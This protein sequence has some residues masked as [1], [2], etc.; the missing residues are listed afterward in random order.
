MQ[1]VFCKLGSRHSLA[2]YKSTKGQTPIANNPNPF[3]P[4]SVLACALVDERSG[5]IGG[6]VKKLFLRVIVGPV[7]YGMTTRGSISVYILP[8]L[9]WHFGCRGA[10][11][12]WTRSPD[13]PN[14]NRW[15]RGFCFVHNKHVQHWHDQP[16]SVHAS[17]SNT[18][19]TKR[20]QHTRFVPERA[21]RRTKRMAIIHCLQRAMHCPQAGSLEQQPLQPRLRVGL[22]PSLT[23]APWHPQ[24]PSA[25]VTSKE[26]LT[27]P[28][29]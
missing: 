19:T 8:F 12:T 29:L 14:F 17:K 5:L 18:V 25:A 13:K 6:A 28:R 16:Q 23:I 4:P 11:P 20:C 3:G 10:E 27:P 26:P 24:G 2:I 15:V 21:C 7:L 22:W 1:H 9:R